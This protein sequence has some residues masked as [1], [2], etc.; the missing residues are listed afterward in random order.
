M[1]KTFRTVIITAAITLFI[2]RIFYGIV[3]KP[4]ENEVSKKIATINYLIQEKGLYDIDEKDLADYAAAG[5]TLAVKDQYTSYYTEEQF[6]NFID[7]LT[8]GSYV[9]GVVVT[10]NDE[11]KIVVQS[12]LEDSAAQKAGIKSGDVIIEVNSQMYSGEQL[13]EAVSVMRGDGIED[14]YG[15]ELYLK[16]ERD[17]KE[18]DIKVIREKLRYNSVKSHM[19]DD[20]IGYLRILAF[21]SSSDE[22]DS[23]DTY[24][25]F[26]EKLEELKK[27]GMSKLIIDLRNNPGGSL[28][29]VKNIADE[30][31]PNGIITYT[32]DKNLKRIE[33]KS[34]AKELNIP[35]VVIVNENSASASEVL[36]GALKD[37]KKATIIGTKTYGKGIVQTVIPLDDGSGLSLTTSKYYTPSGVCIHDIGI[38]P[39]IYVE[40]NDDFDLYE[41]TIDDDI[42]L[43]TAVTTL[44]NK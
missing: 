9:I 11:N 13:D 34:D 36:T 39:D 35:M 28:D 3:L 30:L 6:E 14:I 21:N 23:K 8:N 44:K 2:T 16:L 12:V 42:Q 18:I 7:N 32:E 15:T 43:Q 19:I 24:D 1:N 25:E 27:S 5:L 41:S 33:Y 26:L 10:V 29:V 37:Y 22:E 40:P 20:K 17:D 4:Y 38:E 31:L